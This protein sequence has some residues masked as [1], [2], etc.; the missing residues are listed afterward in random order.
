M[1]LYISYF[2]FHAP[3]Y[4]VFVLVFCDE[5]IRYIIMEKHLYSRKWIR[6]VSDKGME[7]IEAFREKYQVKMGYPVLDKMK[8]VFISKNGEA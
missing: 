1:V 3:F 8:K 2:V 6:P 4:L 7:T 5:P